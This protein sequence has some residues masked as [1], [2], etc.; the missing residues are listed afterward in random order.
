MTPEQ[1]QSF[2]K[3][4]NSPAAVNSFVDAAGGI[5]QFLSQHCFADADITGE[6][7]HSALHANWR[8]CVHILLGEARVSSIPQAEWIETQVLGYSS[9]RAVAYLS[10]TVCISPNAD[11]DTLFVWFMLDWIRSELR[12]FLD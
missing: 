11:I 9:P 2:L 12:D 4:T 7:L 10:T 3:F 1:Y 5:D 8:S 6:K